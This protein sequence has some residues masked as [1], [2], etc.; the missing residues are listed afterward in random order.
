LPRRDVY[1]NNFLIILEPISKNR[2]ELNS[3]LG[4]DGGAI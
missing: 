1:L 3:P 2:F 4:G